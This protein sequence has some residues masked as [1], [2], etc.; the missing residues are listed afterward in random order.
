MSFAS[1]AR[2]SSDVRHIVYDLDGTLVTCKERQ[3]AVAAAV[4]AER[5][6]ADFDPDEFWRQKREGKNT[7][8]ALLAVGVAERDAQPA[9]ARWTERIEDE[10]WLELDRRFPWAVRALEASRAAGYPPVLLTARRE[11]REARAQ[12]ERLGLGGF[13]E[14]AFVVAPLRAAAEKGAVLRHLDAAGYVGDTETDAAAASAAGVAFVAV[15]SGQRAESFL[16]HRG[17]APR[18]ARADTATTLLLRELSSG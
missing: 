16:A 17:I 1:T 14:H 3:V 8:D 6:I 7:H 9:S 11:E 5:D 15:W 18:R 12:I 2:S 4:L 10:E 13:V